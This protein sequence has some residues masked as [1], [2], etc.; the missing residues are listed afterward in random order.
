VRRDKSGGP[1]ADTAPPRPVRAFDY[2]STIGRLRTEKTYE[3]HGRGLLV[4]AHEPSLRL[5]LTAIAAGRR[6]GQRRVAGPST[7]QVL[8]GEVRFRAGEERH[9][10]S[11]G[12]TLVL[13]GNVC[14]D[15]EA[16]SDAAFL[17]TLVQPNEQGQ[18][19][20]QQVHP[21]EPAE[22]RADLDLPG[23]DR[24]SE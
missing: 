22:G 12:G 17:H 15:A 9:E 21:S 1:E 19:L 18:A 23:A 14:Y 13:Q 3:D 4:L 2:A 6:T 20:Q 10:L 8:E 5:A 24:A 16:L 11:A 7:V